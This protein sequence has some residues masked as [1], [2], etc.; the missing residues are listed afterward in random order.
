M[1][2]KANKVIMYSWLKY[3][4]EGYYCVIMYKK[5]GDA[6]GQKLVYRDWPKDKFIFSSV[7]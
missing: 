1:C 6:A 5:Y 7:R 4:S 2:N 3:G